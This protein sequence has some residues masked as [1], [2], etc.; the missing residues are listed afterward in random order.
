MHSARNSRPHSPHLQSGAE[1]RRSRPLRGPQTVR[2][3]SPW[4]R[5]A[6]RDQRGQDPPRT[7]LAGEGRLRCGHPSH[8]P[9][10]SRQP[11]MVRIRRSGRQPTRASRHPPSLEQ[12]RLPAPFAG[13][14]GGGRLSLEPHVA[15]YASIRL[16]RHPFPRH[17]PPP[18]QFM[19]DAGRRPGSVFSTRSRFWDFSDLGFPK[20]PLEPAK[21]CLSPACRR[22][23]FVG[24]MRPSSCPTPDPHR[25]GSR[26]SKLPLRFRS[27]SDTDPEPGIARSARD[28]QPKAK[29]LDLHV[30]PLSE[31][32]WHET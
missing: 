30:N 5:P 31:A 21:R 17:E 25:A 3:R 22:F 13:W 19:P 14:C 9:L 7:R 4:A 1:E 18:P 26:S 27:A 11:R 16:Q 24:T 32:G 8:G 28:R 29:A 20:T 15:K 2:Q 10:V 12:R 6:L 23:P